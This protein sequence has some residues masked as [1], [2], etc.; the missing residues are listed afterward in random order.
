MKYFDVIVIG[1]G[2]SG[3]TCATQIKKR[4]PNLSVLI[5][6]Q[7]DKILK[8]LLKTG[9][10]K[11]N[12]GNLD[13]SRE[14]YYHFDFFK[15][16]IKD[17]DLKEFFKEMGLVIK[18][19]NM[20]RLY[21]YSETATSV[22]NIFLN[23][24]KKEGIEV[25]CSYKVEE[26]KKTNDVF[27]INKDYEA[28]FV[29]VSTG[30]CSCEKTNGYDLAKSLNNSIT[31]LRP[32][33]TPIKVK[34]ETKSLSGIK[35]KCQLK[36]NDFERKG[37]ILFKDD[38]ISG[39]LALEASRFCNIGDVISL[40]FAYDLE[41]NEIEDIIKGD[42]KEVKLNGLL[43]KMLAKKV[44]TIDDIKCFKLTVSGFYG[45]DNSQV[46]RGGVSL[47]DVSRSFESKKCEGVYFCGEVLDIDGDCGGYNL[48][49]AWLSGVNVA[50]N[51]T[52]IVKNNNL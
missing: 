39:I 35:V 46:T 34:E 48:Y 45:F 42:E 8:K 32:I 30:S 19:D 25:R 6:E 22:V 29:V 13:I 37:E 12:L 7:N 40:D 20:G 27:S 51:I 26:I 43:P 15:D 52:E 21:P 16:L 31:P 14:H 36:V 18:S 41:K 23:E 3:V 47:D 10:G 9:N 4:N 38:G 2:A 44:K 5:L 24:I 33:L 28:R 49:F 50:K 11:C 1:G 17:F